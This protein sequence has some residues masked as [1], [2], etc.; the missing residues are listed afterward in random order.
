MSSAL[1]IAAYHVA[2][3][4]EMPGSEVTVLGVDDANELLTTATFFIDHEA[5]CSVV[6]FSFGHGVS[7][8]PARSAV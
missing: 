2:W 6:Q 4:D 7:F 8:F 1:A 5:L 3:R